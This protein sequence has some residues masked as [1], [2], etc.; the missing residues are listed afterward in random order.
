MAMHQ[1]QHYEG[2]IIPLDNEQYKRCTFKGC[3]FQY[4]GLMPVTLDDFSIEDSRLELMEYA[5]NTAMVLKALRRTQL[6]ES[7]D[8]ILGIHLEEQ[9]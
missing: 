7:V 4:R 1:D 8:E 3:T 2:V 9:A 5:V 6:K